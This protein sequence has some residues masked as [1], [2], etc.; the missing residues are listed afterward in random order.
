MAAN[1]LHHE[2]TLR[3]AE[4][5]FRVDAES[6]ALIWKHRPDNH[7]AAPAYGKA[8]NTRHANKPAGSTAKAGYVAVVVNGR[9]YYAHRIVWFLAYGA[10]PS[11]EID[12]ANG[13]RSDNRIENLRA[14]TRQENCRNLARRSDNKSGRAGIWWDSKREMWQAYINSG[15]KRK[16]LG[17]FRSIEAATQARKEAE[18]R[19]LFSDRHGIAA[20]IRYF[21]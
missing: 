18:A 8:W 1:I 21:R 3:Y 13:I 15:D 6:G 2:F 14:C 17:R 19:L 9:S 4:E 20:E 10:W 12:H 16:M 7:F 5:C 11:D